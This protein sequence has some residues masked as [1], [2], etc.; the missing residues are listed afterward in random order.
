MSAVPVAL[1][2]IVIFCGLLLAGIIVGVIMFVIR[3]QLIIRILMP[4]KSIFTKRYFM[5]TIPKQVDLS[6]MGIYIVDEHCMWKT[7]FGY[8]LHYTYNNPE[9]IESFPS[10][11]AETSFEKSFANKIIDKKTFNFPINWNVSENIPLEPKRRAQ[12]MEKFYKDGLIKELF[13]RKD[14][15]N[16]LLILLIAVLLVG[17]LHGGYTVMQ[18][19]SKKDVVKCELIPSLNNTL[20]IAKGTDFAITGKLNTLTGGTNG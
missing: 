15:T 11:V 12:N 5:K 20:I 10:S 2:M 3:R 6:D 17:V 18:G 8:V 1:W 4:D 9:P 13:T 16:I 19:V 7:F 14:L